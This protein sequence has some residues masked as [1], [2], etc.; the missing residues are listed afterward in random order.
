[1]VGYESSMVIVDEVGEISEP[2]RMFWDVD[3]ESITRLVDISTFTSIKL[4]NENI[5]VAE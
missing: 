4:S 2:S 1:M 5:A 3:N